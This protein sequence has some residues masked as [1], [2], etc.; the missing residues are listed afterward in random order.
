MFFSKTIGVSKKAGVLFT[1][2]FFSGWGCDVFF[3][4]KGGLDG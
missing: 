1:F 3:S 2:F 4:L